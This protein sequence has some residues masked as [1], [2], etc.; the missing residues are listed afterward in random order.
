M[1]L[2]LDLP[3]LLSRLAAGHALDHDQAARAF[4]L[5][6]T[7]QASEAQIAA[8]LT[9]LAQRPG[10]PTVDEI[11]GAA[12]T[13]R[14]HV[15]PVPV[16]P[17]I[18]VVDTCGTGGDYAGTF[19]ISTA[20]ALIAAGAGVH[21]AKHGNRS[22]TSKSGSS[23]VLETLGVKL[24]VS[25]ATLT[26]C[27]ADANLCFCFAPAHHPAMKYAAPV[28]KQL[29][30]RTIF[31]LLGPLTN[32]A[33]A[34]R[35]IIGVYDPAL[36]EPLAQVLLNLGAT[37]AMVVHGSGLDEITTAGPTRIT[38]AHHNKL[39][40][41]TVR[42]ADFDLPT[43]ALDALKADSVEQSARIIRSILA[44]EKSP[45]RDIAAVNAAAAL[46]VADLAPDLPAGYQRACTAIDN[47]AAQTVLKRLVEI[48]N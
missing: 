5:V 12:A 34:K 26:R 30:F 2:P 43:I 46:V 17:G 3:A 38:T 48:T 4:D 6:M 16:P 47:G 20:A 11:T 14:R 21:V 10:G 18:E 45:A 42:P 9:A 15:R 28:R 44:G 27:L 13:M 40:T 1:T 24:E 39:T 36:T 41:T 33:G 19:N 35:Q 25:D 32:P 22:T 31:N 8:L 7:G 29:G 23:Q 37:H